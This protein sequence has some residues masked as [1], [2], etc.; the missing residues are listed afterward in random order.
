MTIPHSSPVA[1][2]CT[3]TNWFA[4]NKKKTKKKVRG[5]KEVDNTMDACFEERLREEILHY[6]RH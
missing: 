5:D 4:K 3:S 2:V 1:V 6:C